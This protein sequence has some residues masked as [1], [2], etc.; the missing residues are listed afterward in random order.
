MLV[1]VASPLM[2]DLSW[3]TLDL[4]IIIGPY[5]YLAECSSFNPCLQIFERTSLGRVKVE[6]LM[7]LKPTIARLDFLGVQ[8]QEM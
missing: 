6:R 3:H 4:F 2:A 5:R 8:I 1:L 7:L